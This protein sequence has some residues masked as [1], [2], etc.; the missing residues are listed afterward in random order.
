VIAEAVPVPKKTRLLNNWLILFLVA[1]IL[2]NIG[3][4][5]YGPLMPL[6]LQDLSASVAQVGLF[7]TL[8][9][10]IPLGLQI[11]G[12][13]VSDSLGRLRAIAI[14]SVASLFAYA[15]LFLAPTW[16]WVL[17][18]AAFS[19]ITFSLIGPSFDAF[20]AEHSEEHNRARVFALSQTIF[21]IVAVIGPVL[22][23]WL[24]DLRGYKFMIL[25]AGLFYLAAT[26]LRIFMAR[27]ASK[28][29]ESQPK[30]LSFT[31]LKTNLGSMIALLTAGGVVTW[32]LITDGVRDMSF[33]L[34][35]DLLPIY[36]RDFFSM[37][38][39]QIG[40]VNS[41]FGLFMMLF[42]YPAGILSDKKGERVG[43]SLGFFLIAVSIS[44]LAL[45]PT[46]GFWGAAAGW[47]IAGIGVGLLTPP[48]QSLIS[49]AVPRRLR[50]VA[51][52]F[53]GTS[54][55]LLSLP[56]PYIGAMLWENYD[57]RLPFA[58]TSVVC[59][60]TIIPVWFKFKIDKPVEDDE[61]MPEK[62]VLEA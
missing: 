58:I 53:F 14:G 54:V 24:V 59:L 41:I 27:E 32:I 29:S 37:S 7:F 55:G 11:V 39:T 52:G 15:A 18:S 49:K 10:I 26:I 33:N 30:K 20:I 45:F 44:M 1:M 36:M 47:A 13:Y 21:G 50:G 31:G 17:L 48:Y 60:L 51:Y 8:S 6:Y 16:Q 28:G 23:G 25:I 19:A 62:T 40:W 61:P 2:A 56:A 4:N 22:G 42:M 35:F 43:I 5:M 34:S 46:L 38:T 3:G 57:P 12:G 9:R